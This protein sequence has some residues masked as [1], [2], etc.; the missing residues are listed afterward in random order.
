MNKN[1]Y[2][3]CNHFDREEVMERKLMDEQDALRKTNAWRFEN[4]GIISVEVDGINYRDAPD[5]CDAFISY[6]E[7]EDGTPLDDEALE[8][9]NEDSSYVYDR[10]QDH[11]Y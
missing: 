6:A 2:P 8:E 3:E 10:V 9:L 7:W 11:I 4:M 5:F 1:L